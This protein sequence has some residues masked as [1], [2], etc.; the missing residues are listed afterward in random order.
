MADT[1][2]PS[3]PT[4]PLSGAP[5]PI[6]PPAEAFGATTFGQG[7]KQAGQVGEAI[8]NQVSQ[9]A[10]RLQTMYNDANVANRS[11]EAAQQGTA[12]IAAFKQLKMN[13]AVMDYPNV[14]KDVED[15]VNNGMQGLPMAAQL[16]YRQQTRRLLFGELADAKTHVATQSSAYITTSAK[17]LVRVAG[18]NYLK[19]DSPENEFALHDAM[20]KYSNT[21]AD[22]NGLDM[23]KPGDAAIIQD[24]LR[25][26]TSPVYGT[27]VNR[28]ITNNDPRAHDFYEQHRGDIDDR[29]QEM[30]DR[31]FE[32]KANSNLLYGSVQKAMGLAGDVVDSQGHPGL[33]ATTNNNPTNLKKLDKGMWPGEIPSEGAFAAFPTREAG[34]QAAVHNLTSYGREGIDTL[35][36]IAAKWAPKS[37]KNDPKAY[38]ENLGKSLGI[39][40]NAKLDMTDIKLLRNVA[41]HMAPLETGKTGGIP[42]QGGTQVRMQPLPKLGVGV[43]PDQWLADSRNIGYANLH[44]LY[45][46]DFESEYKAQ[47]ILDNE[48]NRQIA[49][50][51]L[52]I[53]ATMDDLYQEAE[54][55]NWGSF[56][57]AKAAEPT[58]IASLPGT[59]Q[60][61]FAGSVGAM[62]NAYSP[63]RA[64]HAAEIEG[65]MAQ[66]GDNPQAMD[67]INL[68]TSDITNGDRKRFMERM[69]AYK[70]GKWQPS[71]TAREIAVT[72]GKDALNNMQKIDMQGVKPSDG[73]AYVLANQ[74]YLAHK[75]R[76]IGAL[77]AEVNAWRSNPDTRDKPITTDV[78]NNMV[79][80]VT[81]GYGKKGELLYGRGFAMRPEDLPEIDSLLTAKGWTVNDVNRG[82]ALQMLRDAGRLS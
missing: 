6:N 68:Y 65:R 27:L 22:Q 17:D 10:M 62:G 78:M 66:L 55:K 76:F 79:S 38:A 1:V 32:S 42:I 21:I 15:I 26:L 18:N 4:V 58:K 48:L 80:K 44:A 12:R 31:G 51:K 72:Q 30:L 37:D 54:A 35:Y 29:S 20:G 11:I 8:S 23:S 13:A 43:D 19:D 39:D 64:Q 50:M 56:E 60:K 70:Q 5:L 25:E 33:G 71:S 49:P 7:L 28:M 16:Q 36:G 69:E 41:E 61:Q 75:D 57:E 47:G 34:M 81:A 46:N 2:L 14:T 73:E 53:K 40:P 45:P 3:G 52:Q 63:T 59:Y 77:Q 67:D 74:N 24:Q 9:T 82:R